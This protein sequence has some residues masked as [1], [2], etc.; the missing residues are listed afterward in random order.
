L[1]S[2]SSSSTYCVK[3]GKLTTQYDN[4]TSNVVTTIVTT[5]L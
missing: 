2:D 4:S 3:G 1:G 5:K